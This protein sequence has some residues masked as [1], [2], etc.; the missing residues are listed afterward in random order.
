MRFVVVS[1][2]NASTQHGVVTSRSHAVSDYSL[3][4]IYAMQGLINAWAMNNA[5]T[6]SRGTGF[7]PLTM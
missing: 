2:D 6:A 4:A 7:N 5:H 3:R 1:R